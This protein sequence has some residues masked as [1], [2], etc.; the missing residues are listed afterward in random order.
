[1]LDDLIE[2]KAVKILVVEDEA[3]IA[4]NL[5]KELNTSG[6]SA[7][8]FVDTGEKALTEIAEN[9]PHLVILDI[10]IK[11][12][13]D[14]IET[15]EII[16]SQ[17]G[18][19]CIF[20]SGCDDI[21]CLKRA[22]R[23][24]PYGYIPK[25]STR[26]DLYTTVR[27]ALQRF[28]IEQEF[29]SK[30]RMLNATL[31]SISDAVVGLNTEGKIIAWNCGAEKIFGWVADDILGDNVA[32]L[33]PS[34]I[35][36]EFPGIMDD[37]IKKGDFRQ[38]D[39]LFQRKDKKI[40]NAAVTISPVEELGGGITGFS[41]VVKDISDRKE[42]EKQIIDIL[43]DE[44]FRIGRDLHDNLGQYLTGILL[45][46]KVLETSLGKKG[47]DDDK[48][49]VVRISNH[50]KMVL[51]RMRELSRGLI[52]LGLQKMSLREAIH[53]LTL[54]YSR[55]NE[56]EIL[57]NSEMEYKIV[58]YRVVVQLYHITQEAITNAL[59]HASCSR[60]EIVLKTD[61]TDIVLSIKDNGKGFTLNSSSG[62]GLKIMKYRA[63]IINAQ[64]QIYSNSSGS[65]VQCSIPRKLIKEEV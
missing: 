45:K 56:I 16:K 11:G 53:E 37:L 65:A 8:G 12:K 40:F 33:V 38:Y 44:R 61:E 31:K 29:R 5:V 43:E 42:L 50:V 19:P 64:L 41:L 3:I 17:F 59:K 1:M 13:I 52:S 34:Y 28:R 35:P 60:I 36:N 46:L 18:I 27:I 62:L 54:F 32:I 9:R 30:D 55:V 39:T 14:G 22:R 20:Y 58:N 4:H 25:D 2:D 57:F 6:F 21:S 47:M 51:D 7:S 24:E 10:S 49:F 48:A 63:G 15:A 26:I 23:A